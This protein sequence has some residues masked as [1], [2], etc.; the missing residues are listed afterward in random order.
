M[1]IS[2]NIQLN[3]VSKKFGKS[4]IFKDVHMDLHSGKSYAI[5][6]ANG[7]GKSTLMKVIAG[8]LTPNNGEL[9]CT[10]GGKQATT[11]E[12][13]KH[14]TYCA[15]YQE[16]PD[17]M[18][19]VELLNFHQQLRSLSMPAKQIVEILSIEPDKEIRNYSSG[20]KQRV[21]LA[22]AFYTETAAMF[23]DEPTNTLDEHWANWYFTEVQHCAKNKLLV[24]CSNHQPEY[25]FCNEVLS[26]AQYK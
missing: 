15:P 11:E 24:I 25:S 1:P 17:E 22:L 16:L 21:K 9:K 10:L 6:G 12:L 14:I 4:W 3:N 20:M 23:L 19:L 13:Y 26:I 7:S 8:I 2:I 5:T 18:T